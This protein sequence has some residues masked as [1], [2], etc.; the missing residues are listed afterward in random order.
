[1]QFILDFFN[2]AQVLKELVPKE[3]KI[4]DGID[5]HITKKVENN[6]ILKTIEFISKNTHT[7]RSYT[8]KVEAITKQQFESFSLKSLVTE[9]FS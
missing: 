5:F 7:P 4:I 3:T 2:A 1:M 6:R 9:T 8:E